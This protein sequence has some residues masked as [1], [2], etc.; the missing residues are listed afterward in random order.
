MSSIRH[1]KVF[2]QLFGKKMLFIYFLFICRNDLENRRNLLWASSWTDASQQTEANEAHLILR[3][4]WNNS[5][6]NPQIPLMRV[7]KFD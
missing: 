4:A 1:L 3:Y 5:R 7:S 6:K 2:I